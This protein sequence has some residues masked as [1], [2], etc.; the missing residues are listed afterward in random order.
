MSMALPVTHIAGRIAEDI[1]EK[2]RPAEQA[3]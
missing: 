2:P 3:A 1:L